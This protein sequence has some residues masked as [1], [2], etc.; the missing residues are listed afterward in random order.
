MTV[1]ESS[2]IEAAADS[3]AHCKRRMCAVSTLK[4]AAT[5][6]PP[7][8]L[9]GGWHFKS[10]ADVLKAAADL[11]DIYNGN[12]APDFNVLP[13]FAE[14]TPAVVAENQAFNQPFLASTH[15][16]R[17]ERAVAKN[18]KILAAQP[19]AQHFDYGAGSPMSALSEL[20][21]LSPSPPSTSRPESWA[22]PMRHRGNPNPGA[23]SGRDLQVYNDEVKAKNTERAMIQGNRHTN[24]ALLKRPGKSCYHP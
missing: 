22:L 2:S 14:A 12:E 3:Y 18:V 6:C 16:S 23:L 1:G 7:D 13:I 21:A 10:A 15:I 4:V 8:P 24:V 19:A 20:P 9:P 5:T 11:L 17:P